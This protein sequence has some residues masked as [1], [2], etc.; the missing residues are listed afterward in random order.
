MAIESNCQGCGQ[1]LKVDEQYRGRQAKCPSCGHIYVVGESAP[2]AN[3]SSLSSFDDKPDLL[4]PLDNPSPSTSYSA[5]SF[6]ASPNASRPASASQYYAKTP[7]GN[8]YGPCDRSTLERWIKD[9]RLNES[10]FVREGEEGIWQ[11]VNDVIRQQPTSNLFPDTTS[12]SFGASNYGGNP[13][14]N[15]ASS[16]NVNPY[17]APIG[18]GTNNSSSSSDQSVVV[19]VLGIVSWFLSPCCLI[20]V[21]VAIIGAIMGST[22]LGRIKRGEIS[23]NNKTLTLVGFWLCVSHI[24]LTVLAIVFWILIAA[25]Q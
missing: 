16:V 22:E 24:I 25:I 10:C 14:G 15:A 17:G 19:L 12:S 23:D 5:S 7:D 20:G 1:R 3:T 9:G 11:R 4:T 8:I 13:Y 18:P 21:V 2:L 6:A